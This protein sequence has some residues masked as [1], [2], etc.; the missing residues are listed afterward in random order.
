MIENKFLK[1]LAV[2]VLLLVNSQVRS[3][4]LN[5]LIDLTLSNHPTLKAREAEV[6]GAQSELAAIRWQ[7]WPTP[8]LSVQTPDRALLK[9][10]DRQVSLIG[11]KQPLW[12]GGRLEAL[13]AQV[14]NKK[15]AALAVVLEARRDI[16]LELV[17]AYGE[18]ATA[19]AK[20]GAYEESLRTLQRLLEQIRRRAEKGV[21]LQSDIDLAEGRR[22][23]ALADLQSAQLSLAGSVE[24]VQTLLGRKMEVSFK[25]SQPE[26]KE[27]LSLEQAKEMAMTADPTRMRMV[28]EAQELRALIDSQASAMWPDLSLSIVQRQGD[29]TG[30][31]AQVMLQFDSKWGPGLSNQAT[32]KA[33]I[34]RHQAK[35]E[36]LLYRKLKLQE[37]ITVEHRTLESMRDRTQAY[38]RA[39]NGAKSVAQSWDRQYVAGKKSW[40]E[41]MNAAREVTQSQVQLIEM[42][43]Q[44]STAAWRFAILTRG[45]DWIV[46]KK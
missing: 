41:V 46:Q 12:T 8:T 16:A 18:A 29:V 28:A 30:R 2:V 43:G 27:T 14:Q 44:A 1:T 37:L 3:G 38:A 9:G 11:I 17:Q 26:L 15:D 31:S 45:V 21:S 5:L 33:A 19:N 39:L 36:D 24:R 40:Q 4:E 22:Q 35:Q 20:I 25:I 7:Y 32:T 13:E 23:M 34:Y 10:A 42:E 6:S